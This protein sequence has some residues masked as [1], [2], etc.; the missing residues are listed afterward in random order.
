MKDKGLNSILIPALW[1]YIKIYMNYPFDFIDANIPLK[2]YL[3]NHSDIQYIYD[4]M[5]LKLKR[6]NINYKFKASLDITLNNFINQIHL[7]ND[8]KF[9]F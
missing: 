3:Y 9:K 8:G 5:N 6:L 1:K 4:S 7:L 2:Y